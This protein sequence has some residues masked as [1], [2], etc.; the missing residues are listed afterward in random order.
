MKRS[1]L[2]YFMGC[3]IREGGQYP[4]ADFALEDPLSGYFPGAKSASGYGPGVGAIRE[5]PNSVGHRR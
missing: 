4:L 1:I 2:F 5:G 3:K